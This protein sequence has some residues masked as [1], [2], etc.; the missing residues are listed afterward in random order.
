MSKLIDLSKEIFEV[1]KARAILRAVDHKLR[2]QIL[3]VIREQKRVDVTSIYVRLRLEQS[4]CSQHLAIMRKAG[5]VIAERDG[6]Y[7]YYSVNEQYIEKLVG[8][9][10]ELI[11]SK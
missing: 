3:T 11:S 10:E 7:I 1:K 9:C 6:K 2:R 5:I 8:F 4:V